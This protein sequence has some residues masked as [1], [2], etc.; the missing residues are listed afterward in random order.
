MQTDILIFVNSRFSPLGLLR[1]IGED[2][3]LSADDILSATSNSISENVVDSLLKQASK[4]NN[5]AVID[6][7]ARL[8][9]HTLESVITSLATKGWRFDSR[10][11]V[12][13]YTAGRENL[14]RTLLAM[15]HV[16]HYSVKPYTVLLASVCQKANYP[17]SLLKLLLESE[18]NID[19]PFSGRSKEDLYEKCLMYCCFNDRHDCARLFLKRHARMSEQ[20]LERYS[21]CIGRAMRGIGCVYTLDRTPC[22]DIC[23]Q[24]RRLTHVPQAWLSRANL[25]AHVTKLDLSGNQLSSIP[26]CL[27]DGTLRLLVEVDVSKNNLKSLWNEGIR[28]PSTGKQRYGYRHACLRANNYSII[29]GCLL[30]S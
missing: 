28:E 17:C 12:N 18:E 2:E 21:S 25:E 4:H 20:T 10:L 23:W 19:R 22:V 29:N 16:L 27:L 9:D 7:I 14:V 30:Y 13:A 26:F 24:K 15:G 11:L 5:A 1:R 6:E 8:L 3:D